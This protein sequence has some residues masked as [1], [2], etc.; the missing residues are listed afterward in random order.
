MPT[1][2]I[3]LPTEVRRKNMRPGRTMLENYCQE[4]M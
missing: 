1:W 2:V 3:H 4:E